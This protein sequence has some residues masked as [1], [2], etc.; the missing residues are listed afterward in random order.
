MYIVVDFSEAV[1]CL[2]LRKFPRQL[3]EAGH[4]LYNMQLDD[5]CENEWNGF[6][7]NADHLFLGN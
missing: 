3:T 7:W 4:V 5:T 2:H 1:S 6:C